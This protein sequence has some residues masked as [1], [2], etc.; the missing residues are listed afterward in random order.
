MGNVVVRAGSM[1]IVAMLTLTTRGLPG[2]TYAATLA[3]VTVAQ[4]LATLDFG[5]G[6]VA[7]SLTASGGTP[8]DV[9]DYLWPLRRRALQRT[10]A[11]LAIV[12][13]VEFAVF[14]DS[15]ASALR[16]NTRLF[17]LI[18]IQL[19]CIGTSIALSPFERAAFGAGRGIVL[20]RS[21]AIGLVAGSL[22]LGANLLMPTGMRP[23]GAVTGA[24]AWIATQRL[25]CWRL[26]RRPIS[27][28]SGVSPRAPVGIEIS[29][30]VRQFWILQLLS[31]LSFGI[32]QL[33]VAAL[34]NDG[35]SASFAAHSR[36]FQVG[37]AIVSV[38]VMSVWPPLASLAGR[39][40]VT[41]ARR[42]YTVTSYATV[43]ASVLF[44]APLL[45]GLFPISIFRA[46][47]HLDWALA[48]PMS[49]WF[50]LLQW[51]QLLGQVQAAL[52]DLR[53]QVRVGAAMAA[54]NLAT[55][56][57]LCAAIGPAGV[58][59]GSVVSYPLIVL[60][61]VF[62]RLRRSAVWAG[63]SSLLPRIPEVTA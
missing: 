3:L 27:E 60:I 8:G 18:A 52:G 31:M 30:R 62:R 51:G 50:V 25:V 29:D 58:V 63:A 4:L 19:I 56:V 33:V 28:G 57:V 17:G 61:P 2:P 21:S 53:F 6:A 20:A 36:Y 12:G 41:E 42:T 43:I 54:T 9:V 35:E 37:T 15:G 44:S 49:V 7:V 55:S 47:E 39:G 14:A 13:V 10:I 23:I 38:V 59:W 48:I 32:D 11:M 26:V 46:G 24:C 34:R 22:I 1:V 40:R 45:L 5:V 16:T